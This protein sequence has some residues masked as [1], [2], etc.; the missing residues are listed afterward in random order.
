LE[1]FFIAAG[2]T[3]RQQSKKEAK[4]F[5]AVVGLFTNNKKT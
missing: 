4:I 1:R 3:Q 5:A 2:F